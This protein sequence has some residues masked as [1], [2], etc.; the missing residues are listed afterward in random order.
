MGYG[1]IVKPVADDLTAQNESPGAL[2]GATGADQLTTSFKTKVYRKRAEAATALC[3]AIA[4]CDPRDACEIMRAALGDLSIGTPVPP[5][6]SVM[7]EASFW[8]DMATPH[9][10]DAYALACVNRMAPKRKAAFLA[11]AGGHHN[12]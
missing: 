11:Y 2:A 7:A 10:W 5:L 1:Q 6:D 12:G 8:A 3:H 9:E 4:D